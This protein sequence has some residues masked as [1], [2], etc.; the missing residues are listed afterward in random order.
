MTGFAAVDWQALFSLGDAPL[1]LMVRGTA[2]YWFLFVL[3][4]CV[5]RR[6]IGA[7][8]M[9]D[10]LVLAIIAD[11]AQNGMAGE[12]RTVPEGMIVVSTLVF[13]NVFI[14][15]LTYVSPRLQRILEPPPLLLIRNGRIL[16]RHL[17]LEFISKAELQ[18]KLREHGVTDPEEVAA[19]Y[20]ESD[21][22]VTVIKRQASGA[23]SP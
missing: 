21:G 23:S 10:F 13:W 2:M 8:G 4:R 7:V 18:T 5:I 3:F 11:A 22:E 17:R 16:H 19:A 9:A 6:R 20:M 14:D 12:Y 1:E 15:W